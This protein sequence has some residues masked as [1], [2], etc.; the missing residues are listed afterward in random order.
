MVVRFEVFT[1]VKMKIK[2]LWVV[3]PFSI[4]V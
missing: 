3:T 2:V 1:V 4:V